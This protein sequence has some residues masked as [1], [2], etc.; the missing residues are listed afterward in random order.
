M[1]LQSVMC[2]VER[3]CCCP[4]F[5]LAFQVCSGAVA[6]QCP[7]PGTL[8]PHQDGH[9]GEP[10]LAHL[11]EAAPASS[12]PLLGS[13]GLQPVLGHPTRPTRPQMSG[14]GIDRG[15]NSWEG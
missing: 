10:P 11:L 2:S 15:S 5:C 3:G 12:E 4:H 13:P 6:G 9:T 7:D 8:P 14:E 1:G